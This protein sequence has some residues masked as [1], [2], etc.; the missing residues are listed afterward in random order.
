MAEKLKQSGHRHALAA[1]GLGPFALPVARPRAGTIR[2]RST[3]EH[4]P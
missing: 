3:H 2:S 1:T 4:N